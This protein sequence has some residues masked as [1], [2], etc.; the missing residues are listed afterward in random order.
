MTFQPV[1]P[2][3]GYVGWQFLQRTLTNQTDAFVESAPIARA[4]D[5][6][7][8]RI[9]SIQ[10][11]E[12]LVADR[13]L[14]AVALGAFGLDDDINNKAFLERILGDG[15]T[16][17]DALANRLSDK[18][19]RALSDAFGFAAPVPRTQLS[20]FADEIIARYEDKQFQRAVGEQNNDLR[21]AM[22]VRGELADIAAGGASDDAKWFAVMGSPPLRQVF[23]TALGLP[24]SFGRIDIDQ[25]REG[26][27]ERAQAIFGT[28]R[29]TDFTDPELEEQL[30]RLFTIR[31]EA[32]SQSATTSGSVA[33]ALLQSSTVGFAPL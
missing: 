28:D 1:V 3:G 25:Q 18:R 13:E 6:F 12:Q 31:S 32:A 7:R 23:E 30:I 10:T 4:T 21:L 24:S 33:L 9:A 8:D 19:Y 29:V 14:L 20:F 26:F 17:D 5:A 27:Q 2:F 15:T 11:A 16:A 22:N